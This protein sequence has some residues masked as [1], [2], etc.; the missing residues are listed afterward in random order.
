[1]EEGLSVQEIADI[2]D[3]GYKT[4]YYHLRKYGINTERKARLK[5]RRTHLYLPCHFVESLRGLA[6]ERKQ[7]MSTIVR[8]VLTE[9]MLRNKYNPFSNRKFKEKTNNG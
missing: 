1:M 2:C 3:V 5:M 7:Y 4:V 8:D 6:K 9:Y